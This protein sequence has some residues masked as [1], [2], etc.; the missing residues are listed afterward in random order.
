MWLHTWHR[1]CDVIG[2]IQ[3]GG[4][5]SLWV[6][7]IKL[8]FEDTEQ[9]GDPVVQPYIQNK[10]NGNK[11]HVRKQKKGG[12][13]SIWVQGRSNVTLYL[14]NLDDLQLCVHD[15]DV[16]SLW[17]NL[18]LDHISLRLMSWCGG[19]QAASSQHYLGHQLPHPMNGLHHIAASYSTQ[20]INIQM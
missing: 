7:L 16:F 19:Q 17:F 13:M 20:R 2:S 15:H 3:T 4:V 9:A 6:V 11:K 10:L 8:P 18:G 14:Q 1:T 12:L 5:F